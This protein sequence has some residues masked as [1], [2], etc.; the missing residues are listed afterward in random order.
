MNCIDAIEGVTKEI[1]TDIH[2]AYV[3]N[4][5]DD[6]EYVRSV[7]NVIEGTSLFVMG[8]REVTTDPEL[9]KQVLFEFSISLWLT[10]CEA[11]HENP[12]FTGNDGYKE[13][14]FNHIYRHGT[15]PA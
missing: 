2:Q 5:L 15:Y 10:G 9:L 8:N 13:Y 7:R 1:I 14:Y 3:Q 6:T 11:P 4:Q 12:G